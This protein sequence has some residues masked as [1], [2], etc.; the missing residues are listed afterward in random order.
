MLV[1][2]AQSLGAIARL[3]H[4]RIRTRLAQ[5]RG[6]PFA[7]YR[8]VVDDEQLHVLIV[9]R[10]LDRRQADLGR[11][12]L[13]TSVALT[14]V[15]ASSEHRPGLSCGPFERVAM[16]KLG[17][18]LVLFIVVALAACG[19]SD[20]SS[21][22]SPPPASSD[23][24]DPLVPSST[25]PHS[26]SIAAISSAYLAL[27][28]TDPVAD[29]QALLAVV[30]TLADVS[31]SGIEAPGSL[32]LTFDDGR[33]AIISTVRIGDGARPA[34]VSHAAAT[35]LRALGTLLPAGRRAFVLDA[36]TVDQGLPSYVGRVKGWLADQ[37]F[38]AV[39]TDT[40]ATPELYKNVK[41][42]SVLYLRGHGG[43]GVVKGKRVFG[44]STA[45]RTTINNLT[46]YQS[47]LDNGE[48]G[49]MFAP[50]PDPFDPKHPKVAIA[51]YLFITPDFVRRYM[52]FT[53]GSVVYLG[54]CNAYSPFGN[55]F[56]KALMETAHASIVLSW[57]NSVVTVG[58]G[59]SALYLF[60]RVLSSNSY[61]VYQATP[62]NRPFT[63]KEIF[64]Q[65]SVRARDLSIYEN[66]EDSKRAPQT[67][68][69]T[70]LG[71]EFGLGNTAPIL[72]TLHAEY[73]AGYEELGLA[74]SISGLYLDNATNHL[75]L[76]GKFGNG[77]GEA[78][79]SGPRE[80]T[81]DGK[82]LTVES[83]T[84]KSITLKD[85]PQSGAGSDGPLV[86][87]ADDAKS[88]PALINE[89]DVVLRNYQ[90]GT[91]AGAGMG[92]G[93]RTIVECRITVRGSASAFRA[94]PDAEPSLR[95]SVNEAV[96]DSGACTFSASGTGRGSNYSVT[97]AVAGS[98]ELPW[99]TPS[100]RANLGVLTRYAYVT[101]GI[102]EGTVSFRL[103]A[104]VTAAD[105]GGIRQSVN[106]DN[107]QST[108]TVTPFDSTGAADN[109]KF[110]AAHKLLAGSFQQ[111]LNLVT[112]D[113]AAPKRS[114]PDGTAR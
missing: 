62:P 79:A 10:R 19:G 13:E 27:D 111:T 36:V 39:A 18:V 102:S 20:S 63:I 66:D 14:A 60:D 1:G 2:D 113:E 31:A 30:Q 6:K 100:L 96:V 103:F 50:E 84:Q 64:D 106:Y 42:A 85:V 108:Q 91:P 99:V 44:V 59:D 89:W 110:D 43:V 16:F 5:H 7:Q 53:P 21:S 58:D 33:T 57:Q 97:Y 112:W 90:P 26:A 69:Q 8:M 48:M 24:S 87:K 82:A 56:R 28:Q 9:V 86:V 104:K 37:G 61:K 17:R 72:S 55:D 95:A 73:A 52:S 25:P 71:F 46:L 74:P 83:W 101:G 98:N 80:V 47:S 38:D 107:G 54:V 70:L 94:T 81:L 75:T 105:G 93:A 76:S 34:P 65:M 32:W 40:G 88:N 11:T 68:A 67:L 92:S 51:A 77:P 3:E 49:Y 12:G 15:R 22:S 35:K 78:G 45:L 109:G 114:E 41:D 23:P 4:V 29:A